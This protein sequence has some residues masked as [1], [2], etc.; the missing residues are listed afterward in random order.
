MS[1]KHAPMLP[2]AE[3]SME[4]V[5]RRLVVKTL[6]F[7]LTPP[8]RGWLGNSGHVP[9]RGQSRQGRASSTSDHVRYAPIA[10]EFCSAAKCR[11]VPNAEIVSL[12]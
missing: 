2:C 6:S 10:T 7:K 3:Y 9:L 1:M 5:A 11:D 8:S 4:S 12:S